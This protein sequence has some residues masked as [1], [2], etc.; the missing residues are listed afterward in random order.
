MFVTLLVFSQS[1]GF[2]HAV[3]HGLSLGWGSPL[4]AKASD[5]S[6]MQSMFDAHLSEDLTSSPAPVGS[7]QLGCKL[8]DAAILS[9]GVA[10][11]LVCFEFLKLSF[12]LAEER[13][14]HGVNATPTWGYSSRAPPLMCS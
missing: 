13:L 8:F 10:T 14:S 9:M 1:L 6:V 7:A 12:A 11:G 5:S 3:T 4:R 2:V